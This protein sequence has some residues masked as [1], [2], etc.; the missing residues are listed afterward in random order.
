MSQLPAQFQQ[1]Q[2][3][4]A[5]LHIRLPVIWQ[6]DEATL[7]AHTLQL[8][9]H[10]QYNRLYW[11]GSHAP[12]HAIELSNRQNYQLLG[13][14]CDVLVINAFSGFDADLI[15]ASA[16][17]VKAG[18]LWLLLCPPFSQW[19]NMPNPAHRKLLPYPHDANS[20][21]GHFIAFWLQQVQLQNMVLLADDK[22]AKPLQ[23]PADYQSEPAEAPCVSVDQ[24]NAVAAIMHVV[25]GHRRRP[26][27]ISADRGRG[28]SAA[29]GIAAAKLAHAGKQLIITAPSPQA[30]DTA[31]QHFARLTTPELSHQLQYIP[32]DQLFAGSHIA[33]LLL[34]D[35]AAALPTPVLQ[36]LVQRFSRAVFATTEH[37]YEGTGRGFQ[38]RFQQYLEAQ[39]PGWKKLHLHQPIRYQQHDP[40]EQLIF[41]SFL[42]HRNDV[43]PPYDA[44]KAV[45]PSCHHADDW[46]SQPDML[47]QV[48][49]LLSLAHYQTQVTDLAALL[50]NPDLHVVTL[51]QDNQLLA[52]ALISAEG[53][54]PD[55]LSQQIY[56][57]ERRLQGHLLAQSLAFHVAQP[58]LASK[59]LWRIMRIAVQ[60]ALQ[61][62]RLGS[63]LLNVIDDL[64]VTQQVEYLGS[65]FGATPELVNFWRRAGYSAIRL[66]HSTDK[67][68]NEHSLLV[69]KSLASD[70]EQVDDIAKHF[71]QQLYL[72]IQQYPQLDAS[73][74]CQLAQAPEVP[75]LSTTQYEQLRLFA[76][77]NRPYELVWPLLLQWF[78]RYRQRLTTEELQILYLLLWQQNSIAEVAQRFAF[79]GR[80]G[81]MLKL[82]QIITAHIKL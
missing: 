3:Q 28:K 72:C 56:R 15:A 57:G 66:G 45:T 36:Q 10:T 22:L 55:D 48:F 1:W 59:P 62:Q 14:E 82:Q 77:S 7:I 9:A 81:L 31:Q 54:I 34:V 8:L 70:S 68:S 25:Q 74:A 53:N 40:L 16:G 67:A 35:E 46:R 63:K 78:N 18:G 27:V 24:Q 79:P 80:K 26:L 29:L 51:Q 76:Q 52:C 64:A 60:P 44:D 12:E 20:H 65:S 19:Q 33:D 43:A 38:L 2:Q 75:E 47:Q 69:L 39:C 5:Q 32:F 21:K 49:N 42:L 50:D 4:A 58:H 71:A 13:S 6:G 17:C 11:I 41:A 61:R 30:A 37:G 23:W 73:L